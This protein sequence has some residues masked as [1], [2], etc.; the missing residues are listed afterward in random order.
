MKNLAMYMLGACISM[1]SYG[2]FD[3]GAYLSST[4]ADPEVRL[5]EDQVDFMETENF[6]LPIIRGVE[7]RLR[8]SNTN[9]AIEDYRF[10]LELLNPFERAANKAYNRSYQKKLELEQE[11]RFADVLLLRFQLLIRHYQLNDAIQRNIERTRIVN[12]LMQLAEQ[13]QDAAKMLDSSM[14]LTKLELR[15]NKLENELEAL[16]QRI[17]QLYAGE[18]SPQWSGFEVITPEVMAIT[19]SQLDSLSIPMLRLLDQENDLAQKEYKLEKA[20]SRRAIGF[21]Q[22]EYDWDRG[23]WPREHWGFQV[24]IAIPIVNPDKPDL[25]FE[26]LDIM[27]LESESRVAIEAYNS[28]LSELT[29]RFR[30]SKDG[31][32]LVTGKLQKTAETRNA[33][34][35]DEKLTLELFRFQ[36]DLEEML[37][38]YHLDL[39]NTYFQLLHLQGALSPANPVNYLSN[40]TEAY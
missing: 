5:L 22:S 24:G 40:S 14:E 31:F 1:T 21:I 9:E 15:K 38:D 32:D 7:V 4:A 19:L 28:R 20:N 8:S 26:K 3:F 25:Q 10:R 12:S 36:R 23:D 37:V 34:L 16:N 35:Q 30:T 18:F 6:N 27:E 39:L 11:V 13:Q 33:V 17:Q 29:R 2:Q